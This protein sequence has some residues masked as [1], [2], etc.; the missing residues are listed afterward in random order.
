MWKLK[1]FKEIYQKV[2]VIKVFFLQA[3]SEANE[4]LTAHQR[5]P[6]CFNGVINNIN[7][8]KLVW[9]RLEKM[10]FECLLTRKLNQ[11]PLENAFSSVRRSCGSDDCPSARK[12]G[13]AVKYF[14]ARKTLDCISGTNCEI[15]IEETEDISTTEE[16]KDE[17]LQKTDREITIDGSSVYIL[18][19]DQEHFD[20]SKDTL[21]EADPLETFC[22]YV[23]YPF[24]TLD[25][26]AELPDIPTLN[27]LNYILG[28]AASKL[29]HRKCKQKLSLKHQSEGLLQASYLFC[30]L[31]QYLNA[32]GFH[33]PNEIAV[34]IGLTLIMAFNEKFFEFLNQCKVGVK[35]RL[36]EYVSYDMYSSVTCRICLDKFINCILNV[37]FKAKTAQ[38]MSKY[39]KRNLLSRRGKLRRMGIVDKQ[40]HTKA[41]KNGN[42]NRK[43]VQTR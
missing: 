29:C 4:G 33:F 12:F 30:R 8:L 7:G 39:K 43:L 42:K 28:Y 32:T 26:N 13:I 3:K 23:A 16:P 17:N 1:Y 6:P 2:I 20:L 41:R 24:L 27:G 5:Y 38:L 40:P 25:P 11:D 31:K 19:E 21:F 10:G 15:D 18:E 34:E 9:D 14:S 22:D 37:L 35:R 36:K